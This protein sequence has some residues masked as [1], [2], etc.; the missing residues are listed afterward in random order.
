LR[1]KQR[2]KHV[3][4]CRKAGETPALPDSVKASVSTLARAQQIG[5]HLQVCNA[6]LQK[7]R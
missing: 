7:S 1:D 3:E 6:L 5:E 4:W 2:V